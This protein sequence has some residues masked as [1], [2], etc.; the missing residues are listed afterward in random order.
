MELIGVRSTFV[1]QVSAALSTL[2]LVSRQNSHLHLL[3]LQLPPPTLIFSDAFST[4]RSF[5]AAITHAALGDRPIALPFFT[6]SQSTSLGVH[7]DNIAGIVMRSIEVTRKAK[8]DPAFRNRDLITELD[9]RLP[10]E[11]F[12]Q[13]DL[14]ERILDWTSS[15]SP[16]SRR[17]TGPGPVRHDDP[18]TPEEHAKLELLLGPVS[19]PPILDSARKYVTSLLALHHQFLLRQNGTLC[20]AER[21]EPSA[22]ERKATILQSNG[23]DAQLDT[24][25]EDGKWWSVACSGDFPEGY[26]DEALGSVV[27]ARAIPAGGTLPGVGV[28]FT[29]TKG[30]KG[31]AAEVFLRIKCPA[32]STRTHPPKFVGDQGYRS[33]HGFWNASSSGGVSGWRDVD[34]W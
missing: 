24:L 18:T 12:T 32:S 7:A 17:P 22:N 19:F 15:L 4:R 21:L 28:E 31:K 1:S 13:W 11:Q 16:V 2:G 3:T 26:V 23:C 27:A 29:R 33:Y 9:V 8:G 30:M 20:S 34:A 5:V 6:G 14:T 25:G 10:D